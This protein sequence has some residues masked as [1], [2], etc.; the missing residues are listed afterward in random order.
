[1]SKEIDLDK[2]R[3]IGTLRSGYKKST[4]VTYTG[5]G[6]SNQVEH[7]SGRKDANIHVKPI[8]TRIKREGA[9]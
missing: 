3:S 4:K 9:N 6:K 2:Y 5:Y 7:W 8:V 1:M